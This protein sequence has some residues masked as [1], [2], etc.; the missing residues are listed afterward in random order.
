ML[1]TASNKWN[2]PDVLGVVLNVTGSVLVVGGILG[3]Y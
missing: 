1:R 2:I 3:V